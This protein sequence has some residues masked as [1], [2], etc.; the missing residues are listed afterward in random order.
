VSA[1][2]ELDVSVVDVVVSVE[3][4]LESELELPQAV[5]DATIAVDNN[6]ANTRFFIL[7]TSP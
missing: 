1:V 3:V 2:V 6:T 7:F 5:N 4:E